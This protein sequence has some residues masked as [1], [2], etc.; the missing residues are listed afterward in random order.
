MINFLRD[1]F[2]TDVERMSKLY[3]NFKTI[4]TRIRFKKSS[5]LE[6]F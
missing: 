2:C 4:G 5:Q 6:V 3:K 1:V